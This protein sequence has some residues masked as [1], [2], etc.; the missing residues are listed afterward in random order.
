MLLTPATFEG[1]GAAGTGLAPLAVLP[2][3]QRQNLGC[4]LARYI[5][6]FWCL[7]GYPFASVFDPVSRYRPLSQW[8][9]VPNEDLRNQCG[10]NSKWLHYVLHTEQQAFFSAF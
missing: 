3:H 2:S 1:Y 4:R 8:G 9:G 10:K 7:S 6:D 5:L